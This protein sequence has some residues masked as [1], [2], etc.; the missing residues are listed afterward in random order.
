[1]SAENPFSISHMD[2]FQPV[3]NT[4]DLDARVATL[5][6]EQ[7]DALVAQV[8]QA[9]QEKKSAASIINTVTNLI[10]TALK[11]F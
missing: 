5:S 11:L 10:G 4:A 1:M 3:L 7:A 8:A 9:T 6:P 2:S